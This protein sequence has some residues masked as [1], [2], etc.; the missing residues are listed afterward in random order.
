MKYSSIVLANFLKRENRFIAT[1][2]L[3]TTQEIVTV[4]VKNTGRCKEILIPGTLVALNYQPSPKRK[5]AYDLV[6]AKKADF[7]INIDS[8]LPNQLVHNGLK[9]GIINLSGLTG[10][11]TEIKPEQTFQQSKF[12]FYIKTD[13]GEQAFIEVKGM[14][15]ENQQIGA[16]PDA[17]TLRGLKHVNE[18][19]QALTVGYRSYVIFVVQFAEIKEATIHKKMQPALVQAIELGQAEGLTVLAYNCQVTAETV[20]LIGQVDFNLQADFIDPNQE[21]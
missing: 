21:V 13:Q 16:F 17:P 7:W 2:R 15:L 12:D 8:Q 20:E 6:A 1:C 9:T 18:L 10:K 19:R 11:L 5:T 4:H 3:Q 14:T